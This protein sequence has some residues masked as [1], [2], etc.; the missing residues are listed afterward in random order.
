MWCYSAIKIKRKIRQIIF[1]IFDQK[2]QIKCAFDETL[3]TL[4]WTIATELAIENRKDQEGK[5]C[6]STYQDKAAAGRGR[7]GRCLVQPARGTFRLSCALL[8]PS[9]CVV[10]SGHGGGSRNRR[11]SGIGADK[12][13]QLPPLLKRKFGF[14]VVNGVGPLL[15]CKTR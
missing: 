10:A 15:N 8:E 9:A 12:G 1:N 6:L 11:P 5:I 2:K 13:R 7:W 4:S 14:F 3:T